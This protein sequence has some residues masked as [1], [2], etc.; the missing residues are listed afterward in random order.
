MLG[1]NLYVIAPAL[2]YLRAHFLDLK[3]FDGRECQDSQVTP[4]I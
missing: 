2:L 4:E 1:R 3:A